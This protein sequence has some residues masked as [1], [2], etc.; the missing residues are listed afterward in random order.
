M[1]LFQLVCILYC[2][3]FNLFCNVWV[4]VCVGV[5]VTCV[6]VFT[7]FCI[8]CT[9]FLYCFVYVY[10]FHICFVCT[11]V[12]TTATEWELNCDNN[13][14]N[15]NNNNNKYVQIIFRSKT[16]PSKQQKSLL[17]TLI[18]PMLC[19]GS[20]TWTLTADAKHVWKENIAKNIWPNTG[21]GTLASQTEQWTL[22]FIQ[23]AKHRGGH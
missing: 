2:G 17:K 6:I 5:L 11:S 16:N 15:N 3:C 9:V 10:L 14:N 8:V 20:L 23:W 1:W 13:N 19:Y 4:C 18:K 7:V 12:R 21:R 22:H